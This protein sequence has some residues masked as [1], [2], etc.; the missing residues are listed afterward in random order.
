MVS[1]LHNSAHNT[2]IAGQ[3][4]H[5][6][7]QGA[8][9]I[10]S[11]G[12]GGGGAKMKNSPATKPPSNEWTYA[13][14]V[15]EGRRIQ[16]RKDNLEA[17]KARFKE[18]LTFG[19]KFAKQIQTVADKIQAT[20]Q[21]IQNPTL[22]AMAQIAQNAIIRPVLTVLNQ[23]P[24]IV[25]FIADTAQNLNRMLQSA[26]E[27]VIALFGDLKNFLDRKIETLKKSAK[28]ILLIFSFNM[29]NENYNNDETLAIFK[30]REIKKFIVKIFRKAQKNDDN[31]E[32]YVE[33]KSE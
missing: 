22:R 13:K 6:M 17:S 14:C 18:D 25:N 32:G 3:C 15:A 10:C 24:K 11:G 29:D 26:G 9:P 23:I 20:I 8:C 30:A 16:A 5:G 31:R 28:K 1:N 21:N 27:K 4:P 7:P 33:S 2:R 19:Q 12:G